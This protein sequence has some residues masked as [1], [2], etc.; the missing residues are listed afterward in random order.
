MKSFIVLRMAR[1]GGRVFGPHEE[2]HRESYRLTDA[3]RIEI[4]RLH[5]NGIGQR[6]TARRLKIHRQSVVLWIKR[7]NEDRN[8]KLYA[9]D[10]GAPRLTSENED[11]L[12]ACSGV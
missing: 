8:L 12:L 6:T 9:N 4:I 1:V 3:I 11:F 2:F 5:K 10:E 7:Y